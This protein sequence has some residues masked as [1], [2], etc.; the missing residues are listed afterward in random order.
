LRGNDIKHGG[1]SRIVLRCNKRNAGRDTTLAYI[2]FRA[3][4]R[5]FM[6]DAAAQEKYIKE[7]R[8]FV[9]FLA[10]DSFSATSKTH[11]SKF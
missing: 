7:V 6:E 4:G 1:F 11:D 3:V 2:Y 10:I 5:K 8:I 9:L